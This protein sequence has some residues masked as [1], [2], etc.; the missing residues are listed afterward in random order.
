M[1]KKPKV[2]K[3]I[4]SW[5]KPFFSYVHACIRARVIADNAGEREGVSNWGKRKE[6][7]IEIP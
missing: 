5:T 1:S 2:K 6:D 7:R 3:K 4:H